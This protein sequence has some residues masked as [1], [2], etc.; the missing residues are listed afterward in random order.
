MNGKRIFCCAF[1]ASLAA[2][3]ALD[4]G[5]V[6]TTVDYP[7]ASISAIFGISSNG[8]LAGTFGSSTSGTYQGF[9]SLAPGLF[10]LVDFP[11]AANTMVWGIS[12]SGNVVGSYDDASGNLHGFSYNG[13]NYNAINYAGTGV[14]ATQLYGI[15]NNN[16]LMG[17]Y[18]STSAT[19]GLRCTFTGSPCYT[20][21]LGVSSSGFEATGINDS[22]MMVGSLS[23][24]GSNPSE[25]GWSKVV[26]GASA[27]T[28]RY[29]GADYTEIDGI[30]DAGVIVGQYGGD[31]D[32]TQQGF[33]YSGGVY[34]TVDYPGSTATAITGIS[35]TG[36]IAGWY[37][38]SSGNYNG[39]TADPTPEPASLSLAALGLLS[40]GAL[41][42]QR[43]R[44]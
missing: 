3:P 37:I 8:M 16:M 44:G 23:T 35:A 24:G 14:T 36:E 6:F 38:D 18:D 5:Y 19:G 32:N 20:I 22:N 17:E 43:R 2:A 7:G 34:I 41:R 10:T 40:A 27:T 12:A 28:Y 1:L 33:I 9:V 30:N 21:S 11:G 26:G 13:T 31:A 15:N 25:L 4:A 29:P 42:W 39:F